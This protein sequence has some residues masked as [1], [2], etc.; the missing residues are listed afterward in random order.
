MAGTPPPRDP[1]GHDPDPYRLLGVAT[2]ASTAEIRAAYR[3]AAK[4]AHPDAGGDPLAFQRIQVAFEVLADPQ[5]RRQWDLRNAPAAP[6]ASPQPGAGGTQPVEHRTGWGSP[7]GP[8]AH[9]RLRTHW[10]GAE[11]AWT[12]D[13]GGE[14]ARVPG[15][16]VCVGTSGSV[17]VA[18]GEH[19]ASV[20]ARSGTP[21]WRA[22]LGAPVTAVAS[23]CGSPAVALATDAR[24]VLHGL[25]AN[26]GVTRWV[27]RLGV[28]A[29]AMVVAADTVIAV[30]DGGLHAVALDTG[31]ARWTARLPAAAGSAHLAGAG[32]VVVATTVAGTVV[33]V[34]P[35]TGRTRWWVRTGAPSSGVTS[36]AV[37]GGRP[38][39]VADGPTGVAD[40][41]W[42]WVSDG[43]ARLLRLDPATG[44]ASRSVEVGEAVTHLGFLTTT[45]GPLVVATT[46]QWALVALAESGEPR[47]KVHFA[48]PV[49]PPV[50]LDGEVAVAVADG[51]LRFLSSATGAEVH[52]V[53]V[54]GVPDPS[55]TGHPEPRCVLVADDGDT[56]VITDD[57]DRLAAWT[58]FR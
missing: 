54:A 15:A 41:S 39:L 20:G 47:W 53:A 36:A 19:V 2:G 1:A 57:E 44:A 23:A 49:A 51:S 55:D 14:P 43:P 16:R 8:T 56:V 24:G 9:A 21:H 52:H 7:V 22:H 31:K 32:D 5:R 12:S 10:M 13:P 17:L 6:T 11:L 30:A 25:D 58:R 26:R 33:G 28:V 38:A 27:N 37:P 34:H 40:G 45:A 3:R 18:S 4:R 35:E 42:L 48:V 50:V 29:R 46:S